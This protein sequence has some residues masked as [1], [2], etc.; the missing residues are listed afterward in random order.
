VN[1]QCE[2]CREVVPLADFTPRADGIEVRCPACGGTFFVASA[3]PAAA[4]PAAASAPAP[5]ARPANGCVCPKCGRAQ[6]PADACRHCGLVFARWDPALAGPA[7]GDET[8]HGLFAAAA[9]AWGEEARHEAFVAYCARAGCLPFAA[10]CYRERLARDPADAVARAGQERVVTVAEL[11]Y[12]APARAS[13]DEPLKHRTA[14]I[15]VVLLV[16]AGIMV[17]LTAPVW[18]AWLAP[19]APAAG[20][21]AR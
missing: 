8:A 1:V 5:A 13:R 12:L 10:R 20:R 19:A 21:P 4:P 9:A 11:T 2:L 6:P 7:A 3:K 17:Y 18:R 15:A 14:L 16:F